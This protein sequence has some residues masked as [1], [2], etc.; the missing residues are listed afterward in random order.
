M[1]PRHL[2]TMT[3]Y[4]GGQGVQLSNPHHLFRALLK[5]VLDMHPWNRDCDSPSLH[6]V[7]RLRVIRIYTLLLFLLTGVSYLQSCYLPTVSL[8]GCRLAFVAG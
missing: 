8:N 5:V 2:A 4:G 3:C 7:S 6:P 1:P